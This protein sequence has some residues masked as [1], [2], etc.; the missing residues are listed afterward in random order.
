MMI[1]RSG[2]RCQIPNY[3]IARFCNRF[4]NIDMSYEVQDDENFSAGV[5]IT[6]PVTLKRDLEGNIEVGPVN[7]SMYP[8]A[9]EES[10]WLVVG[11]TK[12]TNQLLAIK[13]VFLQRKSSVKLEFAAPAQPGKKTYTLYLMCDPYLGCDQEYSFCVHVKDSTDPYK[14]GM[15]E[16]SK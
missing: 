8:K 6:L 5:N 4:P 3:L 1:G 2:C 14:D 11:D 9:K 13:R 15:R 16:Y 7:A 10:W 12:S